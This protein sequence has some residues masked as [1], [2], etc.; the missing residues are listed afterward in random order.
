MLSAEWRKNT[1][2]DSVIVVDE[3]HQVRTAI[4]ATADVLGRFL[5]QTADMDTWH[6]DAAVEGDK[7]R[8]DAW[9]QLVIARAQ[10]GEVLTMEPQL[11][12]EGIYEWFR[13]RGVDYD[14]GRV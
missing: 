4:R 2:H 14:T 5:T 11:F 9:G 8:P 7:R 1:D 3:Q 10:T 13:S 12:W 6:G